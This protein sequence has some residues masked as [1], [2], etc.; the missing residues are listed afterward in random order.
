MCKIETIKCA[1][2]NEALERENYWYNHLNSELNTHEPKP[3]IAIPMDEPYCTKLLAI[4]T[5]QKL[6]THPS[7][8]T[9]FIIEYNKLHKFKREQNLFAFTSWQR[10]VRRLN[11]EFDDCFA[12]Y[13]SRK[14]WK[15]KWTTIVMSELRVKRPRRLYIKIKK[16]TLIS[17]RVVN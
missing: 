11:K 1:N 2:V 4:E 6:E 9:I 5:N 16:K 8:E 10:N 15:I 7:P 13:E 3:R 17:K 12:S 14:E